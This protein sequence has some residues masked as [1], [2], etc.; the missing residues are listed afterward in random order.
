[1]PIPEDDLTTMAQIG[2]QK[3]SAD[4]YA[5]VKLALESP[6]AGYAD[7]K[8]KVFLQGSYGNET[9]I[10][11]ESDVDVVMRLDSI[12]TYDINNLPEDQK[13]AFKATHPDAVYTH[14]HF[15]DDVLAVLHNRFG[16]DVEP[17]TKAVKIK[18]LHNRRKTDVL[19][20]TQHRKYS[21]FRS[22]GNETQVTGISFHKADGS[23]VVNYPQQH[24][25]NLISK[26]QTTGE[27]FKHIVRIFKNAR[28]KLIEQGALE[29]GVAPSYY[30][31]GLL[32][33]VP[34]DKFGTSYMDSMVNVINWLHE[35]D[36]TRFL[37][38][39]EQYP[40]LDGNVDVTWNSADCNTYL[41]GLVGLWKGW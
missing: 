5:T 35:A 36:R 25:A 17:G 26:N 12:F 24:R 4:T 30:I 40:L 27:W 31:E 15:R 2:A 9:N 37:C 28:Q 21:Y 16:N 33:N 7:K 41:H 18:P 6:D 34:N 22:V 19:I 13:A 10:M 38:A 11:K 29:A 39:N 3:T 23:R 14:R 8:C 20:A 32:Y 1:M